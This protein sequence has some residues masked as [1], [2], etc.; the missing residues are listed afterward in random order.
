MKIEESVVIR[1]P[2]EDVYDLVADLRRAPEWQSSLERVDVERGV[3]IRTFAGHQ[4]E[5][6]FEVT[7]AVRPSRFGIDSQAGPIR[8]HAV[9]TFT[10]DGDGTRVDFRLDLEAGGAARLAAALMHGRVAREARQ[11]LQRLKELL[12]A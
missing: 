5:A 7:E 8:A 9:F 6:K 1:R 10:P 12:E 2:P 4:Q 3:E 11:N